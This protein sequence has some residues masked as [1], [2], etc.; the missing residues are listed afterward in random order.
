MTEILFARRDD[1]DASA[2][3]AAS[4]AAELSAQ[5]AQQAAV[6]AQEAVDQI[7]TSV[8]DA[9]AAAAAAAVSETNATA[10]ASAAATSETNAAGSASAASTSA[11][12]AA[13]SA[14]AA[15]TSAGNASTS[16]SAAAGSASAASTSASAAAGSA[17]TASTAATNAGNSATAAAGS[18][19]TAST[20]AT[21][22]G[23]SASAAAGSATAAGNS[24]T[25]AATSAADA[26]DSANDA[27][28]IAATIGSL[29]SLTDVVITTPTDGQALIYDNASGNWINGAGG[30]GGTGTVT[31]VDVTAPAAGLTFSGG[32]ITTSGAIIAALANDL[33]ALEGLSGTGFS[34]RT[35]VDTWAV[36]TL[37]APAAGF[38]ISEPAGVAGN[39]TFALSDD[40]AGLEGLGT[41]GIV[42]RT[43]TNTYATRA[44]SAPSSGFGIN[45]SA[46]IGGNPSFILN[47]DLAA[48]EGLATTGIARRTGTSTWTCGTAV[49]NSELATMPTLTFKANVTGGTAVPTDATVDQ[50]RTAI[51]IREQLTGNRTYYV[52]SDGSNSNNG[53]SNTS[54]GAFLTIAYAISVV[55]T[56][57][58]GVSVA[59][60]QVQD[61]TWNETLD[62][63][64]PWVGGP[65]SDVLLRGN[66]AT[67]ANCILNGTSGCIIARNI[68]TTI[69]VDGFTFTNTGGNG[70]IQAITRGFVRIG[71]NNV[72]G[73][74]T[75]AHIFM[76]NGGLINAYQASYAITGGATRHVQC[77]GQSQIF[78]GGGAVLTLSGTPAFSTAFIQAGTSGMADFANT[79]ISGAATG[80][81]YDLYLNSVV[82]TAGG[83]ASYFPGSVAGTTATGGQYA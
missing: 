82:N 20:A 35:A 51:G 46:G 10:A 62:I 67:P 54:G 43:G 81:R 12:A 59:T 65:G 44:L 69:N 8:T 13:G 57:D 42:V 77:I 15:S 29:D 19:T 78:Y 41:I 79:S 37:T 16:A 39:P 21:N 71:P 66:T 1:V 83:G 53:L 24:A 14:S 30:G 4:Q 80:K 28:A 73:T 5:A 75:S 36:R 33:A 70:A 72:F 38:T 61:G 7:G 63:T 9:E 23:N 31:S 50:M 76:N 52:R 74:S 2:A 47:D 26:L 25:A 22:A 55:A 56:L 45:Q 49:A 34:A 18:A 6:D 40:L 64:A 68:G 3:V 60:I 11:S 27:A 48:L 58:L 32:P 17:T